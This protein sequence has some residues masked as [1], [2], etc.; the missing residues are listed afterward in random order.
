MLKEAGFYKTPVGQIVQC[1]LCPHNCVLKPEQTGIC[2]VRRNE[3]GKLYTLNYAKTS[4]LALDPMEK[5]PLYH[6]HPGKNIL[7]VGTFGCNLSCSF[8]QNHNIAHAINSGHTILPEELV[9]ISHQAANQNSV[10]VAFTYNEPV[11]WFEYVRETAEMLKEANMKVVLVSNGFIELKPL[12][13]LLPFIDAI[14]IDLKAFNETFYRRNCQAKL[15]PVKQV[16]EKAVGQVHVEITTLI[17][18]GENNTEAEISKQASWLASLNPDLPLHLSRYFPAYKFTKEATPV[19]TMKIAYETAREY[20]EFV[21]LG[22]LQQVKND[23]Y[24]KSC[25][26]VLVKRDAYQIKIGALGVNRCKNCG[27]DIDYIVS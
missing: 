12:Q 23:T 9:R 24:C 8:C 20:L 27:A 13:E 10:G 7:S 5:K 1:E 16:I 25:G 15:E 2:R 19:K 14:N 18:P 4:A 11:I 17:I 6:F 22:N 26:A 21:Y 3:T